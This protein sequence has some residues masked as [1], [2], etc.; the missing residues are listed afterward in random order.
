MM[1]K[2]LVI[3]RTEQI[4][5]VAKAI[6]DICKKAKVFAFYGDMGAGKTTLIK[7]ICRHL[8]SEDSFS[9]PTFSLVNEYASANSGPIYHMD[10]YRL[11]SLEEALDIGLV[12][13]LDSGNLCFIEW[14]EIAEKILPE[15]TCR[16]LIKEQEDQSRKIIIK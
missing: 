1:E 4:D 14:P 5:E 7:A 10:L 9:S 12:D 8:G 3:Q 13:M 15:S 2:T 16:I 11:K 6:A